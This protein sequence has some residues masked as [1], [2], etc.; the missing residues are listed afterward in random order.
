MVAILDGLT[1]DFPVSVNARTGRENCREKSGIF[2]E[3]IVV[4]I[5][6]NGHVGLGVRGWYY[7][8]S[9]GIGYAN[10]FLVTMEQEKSNSDSESR[11]EREGRGKMT[12]L[13]YNKECCMTKKKFNGR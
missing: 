8:V 1:S 4:A 12:L 7:K 11:K 5:L 2:S 13:V 9:Q 6:I 3:R 10:V